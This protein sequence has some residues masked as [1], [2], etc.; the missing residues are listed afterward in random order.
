MFSPHVYFW[1]GI[2]F[3]NPLFQTAFVV[4]N[5]SHHHHPH[6]SHFIPSNCSH[7]RIA[8][9]C[10]DAQTRCFAK[11]LVLILTSHHSHHLTH[12]IVPTVCTRTIQ[13]AHPLAQTNNADVEI[14]AN[15]QLAE[16]AALSPAATA[17]AAAADT[18]AT[19]TTTSA[20]VVPSAVV[21]EHRSL[22]GTCYI[23]SVPICPGPPMLL[24]C[25][26]SFLSAQT[27]R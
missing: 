3:P 6:S 9:T 23:Q 11:L 27:V 18:A 20:P 22:P 26:L 5:H 24:R 1:N 16:C 19:S 8:T 21:V 12:Q 10:H 7:N 14:A 25:R 15:E 2:V 17:A 13:H 4:H